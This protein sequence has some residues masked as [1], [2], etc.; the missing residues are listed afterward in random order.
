MKRHRETCSIPSGGGK[1]RVPFVTTDQMRE[2]DRLVVERYGII[3]LQMMENAGR[4]L[5]HLAQRRFLGGDPR[6]RAVLVLAGPGGNGGGGL[7]SARRLY[8][9]GANLQVW[10][11]AEPSRMA[12]VPRHQLTVLERMGVPIQVAGRDIELSPADLIIDALIGYSLRGAP[13]GG[14]AALIRAARGQSRA[15]VLSMDLP[16][17]VDATTGAVYEPCIKATATLTLALPKQGLRSQSARRHVGELYLCDI[18]VPPEF[19]S[20]PPLCLDVGPIFATGDIVR[21]W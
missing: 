3:L 19:Y 6:G 10:V 11:A 1:P 13:A 14:T 4:H 2:V 18:G 9:W 21:I 5:A 7:V 16:S 12:Q 15:S 20:L 17:G 8:S